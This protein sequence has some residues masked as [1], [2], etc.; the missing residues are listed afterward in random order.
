VLMSKYVFL[1]KKGEINEI[2]EHD[3]RYA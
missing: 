3:E 1:G 2:S